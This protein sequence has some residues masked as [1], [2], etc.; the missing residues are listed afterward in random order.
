MNPDKPQR[1]FF[2]TIY[3]NRVY[4][5]IFSPS[6]AEDKYTL[7][8]HG[9]LSDSQIFAPYLKYLANINKKYIAFDIRGYR[10]SNTFDLTFLNKYNGADFKS[11][12][13]EILG[14]LHDLKILGKI[15][16]VVSHS[17]GTMVAQAM[18][19]LNPSAPIPKLQPENIIFINGSIR[20]PDATGLETPKTPQE[21]IKYTHEIISR[22]RA[23]FKYMINTKPYDPTLMTDLDFIIQTGI[24]IAALN[25]FTDV[26]YT[27]KLIPTI[28]D[29]FPNI[30][31]I[32]TKP[33]NKIIN[34]YAT[35]DELISQNTINQMNEIYTSKSAELGFEFKKIPLK[36]GHIQVY[37]TAAFS[38]LKSIL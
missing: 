36:G 26:S 20:R 4:A 12:Y 19:M 9:I 6:N 14:I 18:T 22:L 35:D 29:I 25:R 30:Q 27:S 2:R 7:F 16:N 10:L 1:K 38:S 31:K 32:T 8:L 21:A 28:P 34:I 33:A 37:S 11:T 23:R 13:T 5:E 15:S 17:Y 24:N 3:G